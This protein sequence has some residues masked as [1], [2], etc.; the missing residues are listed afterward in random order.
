[1]YIYIYIYQNMI[2]CLIILLIMLKAQNCM[3]K[4]WTFVHVKI[5]QHIV[6]EAYIIY[7]LNGKNALQ[8][9]VIH[10]WVLYGTTGARALGPGPWG[11]QQKP[12]GC[13]N[14]D[15]FVWAEWTCPLYVCIV[16]RL[17]HS[18]QLGLNN[19]CANHQRLQSFIMFI[20]SQPIVR[21]DLW[22]TLPNWV[23]TSL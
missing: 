14:Q 6:K 3:Q 7:I 13:D 17:T 22:E 16:V 15:V 23:Q 9:L 19:S 12:F 18:Y 11:C 10:Y 8:W 4:L 2:R 1:M 20:D 5:K 21:S